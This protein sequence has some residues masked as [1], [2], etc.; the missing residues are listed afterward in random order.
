ML[1]FSE[2]LYDILVGEIE[3][4]RWQINDRLPGVIQLAKELDFGTKTIQTTYERLKRAGYVKALGYRG[5]YLKSRHPQALVAAGKIGILVSHTQAEDPL[6][7]W[8]QHVILQYAQKKNLIVETKILPANFPWTD[9]SRRGRLFADDTMGIISLTPYRM[10]ISFGEMDDLIPIVFLVPPFEACVPKVSADVREAYYDLTAQAIRYGHR[11]I[12]FSEDSIEP[13]PRQTELHRRGHTEA[14]RDY[15]LP[16]QEEFIEASRMV[17]NK[18]LPSV[19]KH[20]ETIKAGLDKN[21]PTAVIA[22]SLGRAMALTKAAPLKDIHVPDDLG[23]ITIGSAL[24][25][26][27]TGGQITGMLPDFNNM[28]ETCLTLLDQQKTKEHS[29]FTQLYV[30]MHFVPGDSLKC[31]SKA[32]T[33]KLSTKKKIFRHDTKTLSQAIGFSAKPK[34]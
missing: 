16:I 11:R 4:G 20:L 8:Y 12:L 14:M 34:K 29:D 7:L 32:E 6:S 27:E 19:L 30:R 18:D 13:D 24:M 1:N 10:P 15:N 2:Q 31:H 26:R 5:T 33:L 21:H 28:I 9:I 23:I 22:G 17:N 3:L 25:E